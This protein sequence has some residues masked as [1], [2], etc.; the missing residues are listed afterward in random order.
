MLWLLVL[1]TGSGDSGSDG[2]EGVVGLSELVP[3]MYPF[4]LESKK[5]ILFLLTTDVSTPAPAPTPHLD[6]GDFTGVVLV[7]VIIPLLPP[8]GEYWYNIRLL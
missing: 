8:R 7:V 2:G 6:T 4:L 5:E 3:Q 1:G